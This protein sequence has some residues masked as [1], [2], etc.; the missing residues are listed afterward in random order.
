L[1]CW[2]SDEFR[3][4]LAGAGSRRFL[5]S[6]TKKPVL[7]FVNVNHGEAMRHEFLRSLE[8]LE[9]VTCE[10][11]IESGSKPRRHTIRT[12]GGPFLIRELGSVW[13]YFSGY[14]GDADKECWTAN[15]VSDI[16]EFRGLILLANGEFT[17]G[18][19]GSW[20]DWGQ[21]WSGRCKRGHLKSQAYDPGH[22]RDLAGFFATEL[23]EPLCRSVLQRI[24]EGGS[25]KRFVQELADAIA[26][27]GGKTIIAPGCA[28][29]APTRRQPSDGANLLVRRKDLS[30]RVV[31]RLMLPPCV[32]LV[33]GEPGAGK[34]TFLEQD[35]LP[36]LVGRPVFHAF[37]LRKDRTL[38]ETVRALL[39]SRDV[40]VSADLRRD[41]LLRQ[42]E[43]EIRVGTGPP[44]PGATLLLDGLEEIID[45]R[46]GDLGVL[47]LNP[48]RRFT[49]AVT[50]RE[51]PNLTLLRNEIARNGTRWERCEF[52]VEPFSA[53]EI[54]LLAAKLGAT[55]VDAESVLRST[56]GLAE[57]VN[58]HLRSSC[59][60]GPTDRR[61]ADL[62][63]RFQREPD[64]EKVAS[65]LLELGGSKT[66]APDVKELAAILASDLRTMEQLLERNGDYFYDR[67]GDGLYWVAA[68]LQQ[69]LLEIITPGARA[70]AARRLALRWK[71]R[72]NLKKYVESLWKVGA[73]EDPP[74]RQL[75]A[76]LEEG[77]IGHEIAFREFLAER[78]SSRKGEEP[79]IDI[80][81]VGALFRLAGPNA[82]HSLRRSLSDQ[83]G[84][85]HQGLASRVWIG[86]VKTLPFSDP[87]RQR[88]L[89]FVSPGADLDRR[90]IVEE[91]ASELAE[92]PA[93]T[94]EGI[95][96]S[97]LD[98]ILRGQVREQ[99]GMARDIRVSLLVSLGT[100]LCKDSGLRDLGGSELGVRFL[101]TAEVLCDQL[102]PADYTEEAF[103]DDLLG[104]S[105]LLR[106]KIVTLNDTAFSL[107]RHGRLRE[108]VE[109]WEKAMAF[110]GAIERLRRRASAT[111]FG[112][113]LL[114]DAE[115]VLDLCEHN[116]AH[117]RLLFGD[118]GQAFDGSMRV[119]GGR[120]GRFQTTA[121][122]V[123]LEVVSMLCGQ[124][125]L[126]ACA[127][128]LAGLVAHGRRKSWVLAR[129]AIRQQDWQSA[130]EWLEKYSA[131]AGEED[132]IDHLTLTL[133][134]QSR[135]STAA[136]TL[137][138][139]ADL[140]AELLERIGQGPSR[141]SRLAFE[142]CLALSEA[143]IA[144]GDLSGARESLAWASA[145][146][147]EYGCTG[148]QA[149]LDDGWA[150][151]LERAGDTGGAADHRRRAL[152][153]RSALARQLTEKAFTSEV[154]LWM[155]ESVEDFR[156]VAPELAA[157]LR[158]LQEAQ[159]FGL[160]GS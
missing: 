62:K 5:E 53:Q 87:W 97:L 83:L 157:G 105:L 128:F 95:D 116:L 86:I 98:G 108:S 115:R 124:A 35:V 39:A 158:D 80:D 122:F 103:G 131:F 47:F 11:G 91:I 156:E 41:E 28:A 70:E 69:V 74:F 89:A 107:K 99:R 76:F 111:P 33:T 112:V 49:T 60:L 58:D 48:S 109:K 102:A 78:L 43:H 84:R 153:G 101:A 65:V 90:R 154:R 23:Q 12:S 37:G 110:R 3:A 6:L 113:V 77:R 120:L 138:K 61:P 4:E 123:S 126:A 152:D 118:V 32:V 44:G 106:R 127:T 7:T 145:W 92:R 100:R 66:E 2:S 64:L 82:R 121:A 9:T 10:S 159:V 18:K 50:A 20:R 144:L 27:E 25:N 42:L 16:P 160:G 36:G 132:R 22:L 141:A 94:L 117:Q 140:A 45:F 34:S 68:N 129:Y 73:D 93:S 57:A 31:E 51:S 40:A 72:G 30:A 149:D 55:N 15:V 150:A 19:V 67:D 17:T 146:V 59:K 155:S 29:T 38:E 46:P 24:G 147:E 81:L 88:I 125:G 137:K 71:E 75:L 1:A 151:L 63:Q 139:N 133:R 52:A 148:L 79:R 14:N 21:K 142:F 130:E 136:G 85:P 96:R 135:R 8:R 114:R 56:G 13:D 54:E 26:R 104:M 119:L 143:K 134:L